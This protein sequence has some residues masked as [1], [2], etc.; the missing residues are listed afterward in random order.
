M[1]GRPGDE[2]GILAAR[3]QAA[4]A[5]G[6]VGDF[7]EPGCLIGVKFAVCRRAEVVGAQRADRLDV[8]L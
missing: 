6:K 3:V 2:I 4:N 8:V 1:L 7:A 5:V